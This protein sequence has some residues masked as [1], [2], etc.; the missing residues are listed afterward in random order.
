ME[1]ESTTESRRPSL[2]S[3][4]Q[5]ADAPYNR[6][7]G[8]IAAWR[9]I[10]APG[11][12]LR[13]IGQGIPLQWGPTGPPP[14]PFDLGE[15]PLRSAEQRR[16]WHLLREEYLATGAIARAAPSSDARISRA[17]LVEKGRDASGTMKFRLVIDLRRINRHLRKVGLR[18]EKLR[19]FGT[20]LAKND[21]LVGFDIK[22]A[23]HHLRVRGDEEH[24]L[25]FRMDG[26]LFVCKAL[27]FG[28]SLAPFY[29]THLM[30]VITRFLRSPASCPKA[31][32]R[33]RFGRLAG[34]DA[35]DQYYSKYCRADPATVLAY[36]DDF[37]ASMSDR[38]KLTEW[39]VLVRGVFEVLGVEFKES[40]CQWD[41][42]CCKRH[43]G[44]IVDTSRCQFL[45]PPDKI[46]KISAWAHRLRSARIV[47]ARELAQ[48]C[49][50]AI[51][52][53]LAFP[54]ARFF[55]VSL[56]AVLRGKK[57]W[58]THLRLSPQALLDL[59]AWANIARLNGRE[60]NPDAVPFHGTLATDASL[61]GWGA[62]YSPVG[63]GVPRLARGFF[64]SRIPA[65]QHSGDAGG[66]K[67]IAFIFS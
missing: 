2:P 55:L 58:R 22:N 39:T 49:G 53:Y 6:L 47:V 26:E 1:G 57:S 29:F 45:I 21:S 38:E 18:Y 61:T 36:L 14:P 52:V 10:G 8:R 42:V 9:R 11:R 24:F 15:Y 30:L 17:F 60:L 63:T 19:D 25:Y 40:K 16:G 65:H 5:L 37:L 44:V 59:E 34:K 43:L 23:Y 41:P 48:F 4:G 35:L 31:A 56:Y 32:T 28:L 51:S 64:R 54:L 67:C 33:F 12:V 27:P 62:T 3:R 50:L 7:R 66:G 13:W 20:L 46:A